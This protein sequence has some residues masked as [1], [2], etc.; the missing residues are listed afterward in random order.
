M[1]I[2]YQKNPVE[3]VIRLIFINS[4]LSTSSIIAYSVPNEWSVSWRKQGER[5]GS[6]SGSAEESSILGCNAVSL[7]FPNVS[8]YR[9]AF[10]SNVK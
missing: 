3:Y 4:A 10:T 5:W 7:I 8:R 1:L 2:I 6:E 9:S